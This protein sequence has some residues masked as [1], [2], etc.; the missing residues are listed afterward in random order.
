MKIIKILPKF[1]KLL[2]E[3]CGGHIGAVKENDL[4]KSKDVLVIQCE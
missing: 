4:I 3:K 2:Q 1:K